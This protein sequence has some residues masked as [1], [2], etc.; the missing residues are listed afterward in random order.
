MRRCT[1]GAGFGHWGIWT[2]GGGGVRLS[3][4]TRSLRLALPALVASLLAAQPAL[5]ALAVGAKAPDFTT[6][7]AEAGK[8]FD[9]ALAKARAKGPVVLYFYPKAFTSGCTMEAHAFAEAMGDFE[10]AG[11]TVVGMSADSLPTLQR[12][13][14]EHCRSKFPVAVADKAVI[15]QYDVGL[16]MGVTNRTTYVIDKSGTVR[17]AYTAMDWREHV[18]KAL[19]AVKALK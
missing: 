8:A 18:G 4:M 11:A 5:A 14:T 13:S 15:K 16:M 12:F 2:S 6:K 9:F 3:L 10:K 7:G 19:E 1:E 17:L